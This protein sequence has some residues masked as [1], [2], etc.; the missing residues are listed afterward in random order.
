MIQNGRKKGAEF[1]KSF[2]PIFKKSFE[3]MARIPGEKVKKS[4]CRIL[5]IWQERGIYES[6]LIKDFEKCY[7]KA[8]DDLHG[9]DDEEYDPLTTEIDVD[10]EAFKAV[11]TSPP[12]PSTSTASQ[13]ETDQKK[14]EKGGP[15]SKS[16]ENR[17]S[18][19]KKNDIHTSS[20]PSNLADRKKRKRSRKDEIE[21]ILR[22][23]SLEA[24]NTVEEWETDGVVQLEVKLSP[25][26]F[27]E[28]PTEEDLIRVIKVRLQKKRRINK[29][30]QY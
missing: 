15:E 9:G 6:K 14:K 3:Y 4:V 19:S 25:S 18:S 7:L 17:H 8:W 2:A 27:T 24:T 26:P 30:K 28:P 22:K 12:G 16:K 10:F 23:R 21:S 5:G 29:V 11:V 13:D 20:K 1:L